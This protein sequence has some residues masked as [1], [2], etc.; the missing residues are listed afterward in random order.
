MTL[1]ASRVSKLGSVPVIGAERFK[2]WSEHVGTHFII[3][4]AIPSPL[5][6]SKGPAPVMFVTDGNICFP[7]AASL[8]G[9]LAMEPDGPP[10][11]L[12]VGIGYEVSG[13]GEN[14]EHHHVR[15]R[16][17]TPCQ[18]E[19]FASMMR[20]APQPFTWREDITPGGAAEFLRF[21]SEELSP[22][23]A[24]NFDVELENSTICGISLGGLFV[25]HTLL[26][27]P[28]AFRRYIAV[29]PAIWW[30]NRSL[31]GV[32]NNSK[33]PLND[34]ELDVF[35]AVGEREESADPQAGMV[36]NFREL[37]KSL[38][39]HNI[40]KLHLTHMILAGESHMSV[41]SPALSR[42]LR[43]IFPKQSRDEGW[44]RLDME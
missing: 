27:R 12:V 5:I 21:I 30:A 34:C 2:M 10:P 14:A 36:S 40:D 35:M 15:N 31:L 7:T 8:S 37:A 4:V 9:A 33:G 26:T 42:A 24:A 32:A 25:L 3:D 13:G 39:S 29:S 41:F 23:L 11:L 1:A 6:P 16:D 18:D 22:W 38:D 28:K 17:L 43:S 19:R 44:A 20:H